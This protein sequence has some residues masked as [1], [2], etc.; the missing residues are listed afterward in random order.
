MILLYCG[1]GQGSVGILMKKRPESI[2]KKDGVLK[3]DEGSGMGHE[4]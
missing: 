4:R 2:V 1:L 3:L